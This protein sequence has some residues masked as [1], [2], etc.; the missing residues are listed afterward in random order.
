MTTLVELWAEHA[1]A[2]SLQV[3][4]L[5]LAAGVLS[6]VLRRASPRAR[7]VVWGLVVTRAL[8][9]VVLVSPIGLIP[10]PETPP[11]P[12]P[13]DCSEV[14]E[15]GAAAMTAPPAD[16]SPSREAAGPLALPPRGSI[17]QVLAAGWLLGV[18]GLGSVVVLRHRRLRREIGAGDPAPAAIETFVERQRRRLGL[19]WPVTVR[20]CGSR[21]PAGLAVVG[22]VRPVLVLPAWMAESWDET[23]FGPLVVHELVHLRRRDGWANLA[24]TVVQVLY[25]FHPLVWLATRL[26]V[27]ERERVCDDEVVAAYAGRSAP[28][29]RALC[30]YA[31]AP[32]G[33]PFA[34]TLSSLA[35]SRADLVRRI[36]RLAEPGYRA[37]GRRLV[38][39]GLVLAAIVAGLVASLG[40]RETDRSERVDPGLD[41]SAEIARLE[42]RLRDEPNDLAA[43]T[44]V[45]EAHVLQNRREDRAAMRAHA[46]SLAEAEE[47][48]DPLAIGALAL[49]AGKDERILDETLSTWMGRL[50]RRPDDGTTRRQLVR[51]AARHRPGLASAAARR[52]EALEPDDPFWPAQLG[53]MALAR[54]RSGSAALAQRAFGE[55][56][57][58]FRRAAERAQGGE[59]LQAL[60]QAAR[61]ELALGR[62]AEAR[63][64]AAL[65]LAEIGS[66]AGGWYEGNAVHEA[67]VLLGFA[68]LAEGAVAEAEG[69]LRRAGAAP[70]SPQLLSFGPDMSLAE[71]LLRLERTDAVLDYLDAC[72]GFWEHG[73]DR[74]ESWAAQ[75]RR[76]ERPDFG[77]NRDYYR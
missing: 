22:V 27:R 35:A 21:R 40:A 3:G 74:L 39:R 1:L 76:G 9:P 64:L 71:A 38:P 51:F 32:A 36:E 48:L 17:A 18:L 19:D 4:A 23:V 53:E 57:D 45:L 58:H 43:R 72:R 65:E 8:V 20:V 68:A 70:S 14:S 37:V 16:P 47:P 73:N 30:R 56:A 28:Y 50:R 5:V 2:L 61:A 33:G 44:G 24:V 55:A 10:S 7:Y 12:A 62:P 11:P 52:G 75:I 26:L 59:R 46:R 60:A 34:P 41:L 49:A 29:V 6:L 67:H 69:H 42:S 25:F 31:L 66:V 15:Q 54:G 13:V 63:R 77:P